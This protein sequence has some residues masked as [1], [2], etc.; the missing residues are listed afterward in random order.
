MITPNRQGGSHRRDT[1]K[2]DGLV[3][4]DGIPVDD[5]GSDEAEPGGPETL[6]LEGAIADL[7]QPVE[8]Y[9]AAQ[10]IAGLALVE[11]SM[12][13]LTQGWVGQPLQS[14]QSRS[15]RPKARSARDRAFP[16]PAAASFR[17][18]T[19]GRTVLALMGNPPVFNGACS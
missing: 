12:A 15:I 6:V 5:G 16:P 3:E 11:P 17:K 4:I 8:E 14:E 2:L 9:G 19:E 18:M 1:Q 7:A 13:A 10:G